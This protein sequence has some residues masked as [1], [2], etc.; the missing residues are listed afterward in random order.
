MGGRIIE[1]SNMTWSGWSDFFAM[2]GYGLYVWGAYSVAF[3]AIAVEVFGIRNR[4][5]RALKNIPRAQV[6][7]PAQVANNETPL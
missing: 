6:L 7:S 2:G 1:G 5:R 4:Q 3:V